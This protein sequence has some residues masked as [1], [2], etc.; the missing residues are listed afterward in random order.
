M[1]R[2]SRLL[3]CIL[4][5]GAFLGPGAAPA[6]AKKWKTL[7]ECT[8]GRGATR[9]VITVAG[10]EDPVRKIKFRVRR[11]DVRLLD[12]KIQFADGDIQDVKL[13]EFV[14]AG[15]S[16]RSIDLYG[17]GRSIRRVE[18]LC[19]AGT[20]TGSRALVRLVGKR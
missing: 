11:A 13:R 7:G 14:R 3:A 10:Q 8:V 18:F 16:S 2:L 12:V 5:A 17:K 20:G 1:P 6:Q 19:A 15:K 4:L 9:D